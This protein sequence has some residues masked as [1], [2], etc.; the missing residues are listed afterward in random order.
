MMELE[1]LTVVMAM[2]GVLMLYGSITNRNPLDV[3]QKAL[4]G[5]DISTAAPLSGKGSQPSEKSQNADSI[6]NPDG[7]RKPQEEIDQMERDRGGPSV[8]G[9]R[10]RGGTF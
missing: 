6:L 8:R 9:P 1:T 10:S 7:T 2:A 4:R 3:I 5:Q